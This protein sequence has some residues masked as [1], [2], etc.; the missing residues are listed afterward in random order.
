MNIFCCLAQA[1]RKSSV[2]SHADT[3]LGKGFTTKTG[4]NL[5]SLELIM[6]CWY[7]NLRQNFPVRFFTSFHL[8]IYAKYANT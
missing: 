4:L 8:H 7:K 5:L 6:A 3:A 2:L 1:G